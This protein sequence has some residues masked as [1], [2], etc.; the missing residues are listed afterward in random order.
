MFNHLYVIPCGCD[1]RHE[2]A[3]TLPME[4]VTVPMN[5][6]Q[7]PFKSGQSL[8]DPEGWKKKRVGV[9]SAN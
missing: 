3:R 8:A 4:C 7:R 6:Q 1:G 2:T 9:L 5:R